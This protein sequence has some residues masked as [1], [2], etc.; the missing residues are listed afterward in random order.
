MDV[1]VVK[2]KS[3]MDHFCSFISPYITITVTSLSQF[4]SMG[5]NLLSPAA[6]YVLNAL[7]SQGREADTLIS[8]TAEGIDIKPLYLAED[9]ECDGGKTP[10]VCI[11]DETEKRWD[12]LSRIIMFLNHGPLCNGLV[13]S[14]RYS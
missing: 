5:W 12:S 8:K 7:F 4:V 1:G 9:R 3:I 13:Y 2:L 14:K 10:E 6:F 11:K